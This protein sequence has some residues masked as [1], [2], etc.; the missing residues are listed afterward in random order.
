M[1]RSHSFYGRAPFGM[2]EKQ[3][4]TQLK[5]IERGRTGVRSGGR[6]LT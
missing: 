1:I 3:N 6:F 2:Q 4:L 5:C